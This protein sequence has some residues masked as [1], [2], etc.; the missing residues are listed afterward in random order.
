MNTGADLLHIRVHGGVI[1]NLAVLLPGVEGGNFSAELQF[2]NAA[3]TPF[4]ISDGLAMSNRG[5]LSD[6]N[7]ANALPL[8]QAIGGSP[9]VP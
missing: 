8:N 1:T 3:P 6:G 2:G 9:L 4:Q 5:P 7:P